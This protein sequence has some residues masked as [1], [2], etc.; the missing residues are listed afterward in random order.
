MTTP[1]TVSRDVT[2]AQAALLDALLAVLAEQ[3]RPPVPDPLA[4]LRPA[5]FWV[6]KSLQAL[7][8]GDKAAS[9]ADYAAWPA[10]VPLIYFAGWPAEAL[11]KLAAVTGDP[12]LWDEAA[13]MLTRAFATVAANPGNRQA[14]REMMLCRSTMVVRALMPHDHPSARK[15]VSGVGTLWAFWWPQGAGGVRRVFTH[16]AWDSIVAAVGLR[17]FDTDAARLAQADELLAWAIPQ[18]EGR[19]A[20]ARHGAWEYMFPGQPSEGLVDTAHAWRDAH[21]LWALS[22]LGHDAYA[23]FWPVFEVAYAQ[24]YNPD[25]RRFLW[26]AGDPSAAQVYNGQVFPCYTQPHNYGWG[27]AVLGS[28]DAAAQRALEAY[29]E[30]VA[31][32]QADSYLAL[33]YAQLAWNARALGVPDAMA[34][35]AARKAEG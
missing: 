14:L 35:H 32:R 21:G 10:S 2:P 11:A 34:E 5:S 22:L 27:W 1:A 3:A 9:G 16:A 26:V 23:R 17:V 13:D 19:Y 31:G 24:G 20:A 18:I 30:P 15:L 7:R 25:L 33:V 29:T 12:A 8:G 4:G 28:R 6:A